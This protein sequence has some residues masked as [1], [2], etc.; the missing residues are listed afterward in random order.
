MGEEAVLADRRE[1]GLRGIELLLG[2]RT[3]CTSRGS[4]SRPALSTISNSI[5]A[6]VEKVEILGPLARRGRDD[7]A[8]QEVA[9]EA[10][11]RRPFGA[12]AGYVVAA[13]R[14]G[15]ERGE[16]ALY[17]EGHQQSPARSLDPSII[18]SARSSTMWH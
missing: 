10:V 1:R 3:A 17:A 6:A 8:V 7:A 14:R 16:A 12:V 9:H 5:V 11:G 18:S 2:L 4:V 15:A 13:D